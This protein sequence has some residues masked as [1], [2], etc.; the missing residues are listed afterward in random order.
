MSKVDSKSEAPDYGVIRKQA[1][2]DVNVEREKTHAKPIGEGRHVVIIS[3]FDP[4]T[5][6]AA[7]L[8]LRHINCTDERR[9]VVRKRR[10]SLSFFFQMPDCVCK[11]ASLA[12]ERST[13]C[14]RCS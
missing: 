13:R 10:A 14:A 3:C 6:V 1:D 12:V 11:C 8:V 7:E 9:C 2:Y 4:R 5:D